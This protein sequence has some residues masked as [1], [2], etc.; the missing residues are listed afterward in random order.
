VQFEVLVN[1]MY[2]TKIIFGFISLCVVLCGIGILCVKTDRDEAQTISKLLPMASL[3]QYKW[4]RCLAALACFVISTVAGLQA[5][6][7]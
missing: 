7:V 1:H 5:F 4:F 3:Y 2:E 6:D